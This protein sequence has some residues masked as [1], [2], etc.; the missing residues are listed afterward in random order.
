MY[1]WEL[2]GGRGRITDRLVNMQVYVSNVIV[3][4]VLVGEFC[5]KKKTEFHLIQMAKPSVSHCTAEADTKL[6][7][8]VSK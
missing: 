7:P 2:R 1:S 8:A 5:D 6:F 3:S 4:K